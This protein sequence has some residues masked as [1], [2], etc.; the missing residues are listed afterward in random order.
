MENHQHTVEQCYPWLTMPLTQGTFDFL[1]HHV[2]LPPKLPQEHDE[3][4]TENGVPQER[5]LHEYVL[6][7]LQDY[8]CKSP[9][10][11]RAGLNLT[12]GMLQNWLKIQKPDGPCEKAL[13][14]KLSDLRLDG[15]VTG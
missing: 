4:E 14:Q 7:V 6:A 9:S 8:I 11:F 1:F 12:Q 13:A 15:T 5:E 10:E 3:D 2:V